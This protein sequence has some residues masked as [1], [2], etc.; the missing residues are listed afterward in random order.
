MDEERMKK[1]KEALHKINSDASLTEE[2]KA[3]LRQQLFSNPSTIRT[4]EPEKQDCS[5][6]P[7]YHDENKTVFGCSHYQR[8]AKIVAK[9][10]NKVYTCRFCHDEVSDHKIVRFDTEEMICMHCQSRQPIQQFCRSS[11]CGERKLASYYC[12]ICKFFDNAKR[13]IYHCPGCGICRVGKGLG[14]DFFHCNG[15]NL[16]FPIN[17]GHEC[18][19]VDVR[20]R[21]CPV[22]LEDLFQSRDRVSLLRCSHHMHMKCYEEHRRASAF[23]VCPIC[24]KSLEAP[25]TLRRVTSS[26]PPS[27]SP[28]SESVET[29]NR[30]P[31]VD[32]S[33]R[34]ID[35]QSQMELS[36]TNPDST[37]GTVTTQD[38]QGNLIQTSP[39]NRGRGSN[40][41]RIILP[42]RNLN[43]EHLEM[44]FARSLPMPAEYRHIK[45]KILCNDC[46]E[47]TTA[48]YHF[49]GSWCGKCGSWNTRLISTEPPLSSLGAT[50]P[51][52]TSATTPSPSTVSEDAPTNDNTSQTNSNQTE[53][54]EN[55]NSV[56]QLVFSDGGRATEFHLEIAYGDGTNPQLE[57]TPSLSLAQL[58]EDYFGDSQ[59][60]VEDGSEHSEDEDH[61]ETE[62][63]DNRD[64]SESDENDIDDLD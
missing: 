17:G 49:Y 13:D 3:K 54:S 50:G 55:E 37:T 52:P 61:S 38:S 42:N 32:T 14:I 57:E 41:N 36:E 7:S 22:C 43:P 48:P 60:N 46:L 33:G 26:N 31:Q 24:S 9:C 23:A 45:A 39:R 10:C 2:Q 21:V 8:E 35:N 1:L 5:L 6:E 59:D 58:V 47:H 19:G 25:P 27:T 12:S 63:E 30:E 64:E 29:S 18:P 40:I 4:A 34:Q 44:F 28:S 51:D 16:C 11:T 53:E 20:E 15:C 62:E 56:I